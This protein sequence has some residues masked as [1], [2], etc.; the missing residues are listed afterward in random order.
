MRVDEVMT[1]D[2]VTVPP[3]ASLKDV[4][5]ALVEHGISGL[6]V[7]DD[8]GHVLG[9]VSE[10]DILVKERGVR[11]HR[12]GSLAWLVDGT[13]YAEVRKA[14]AHTAGEAMSSPAVTIGTYRTVAEAARMMLERGI[15]RL[16]VVR[17]DKLVGIVTRADLVRAFMRSDTEIGRE[18]TEEVEQT[19]WISPEEVQV[20]VEGGDVMLKGQLQARS[21]AHL[22]ARLASRVPGVVEVHSELTW[23]VDDIGRRAPH[24]PAASHR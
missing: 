14:T 20:E 13:S 18:I 16:P 22:L 4:A 24:I 17:G 3:E 21:D 9:V 7:C 11:R 2:V 6:P 1:R 8:D 15:N 10:W 19:L 23:R 5:A 12:G